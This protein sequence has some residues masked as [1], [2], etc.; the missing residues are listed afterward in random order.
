M[1]STKSKRSK[2]ADCSWRARKP[3]GRSRDD[4]RPPRFWSGGSHVIVG[5][6]AES[7]RFQGKEIRAAMAPLRPR[8]WGIGRYSP[9]RRT[10]PCASWTRVRRAWQHDRF[11]Q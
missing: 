9:N 5:S 6:A 8:Q 2:S 7:I 11:H 1:A 3:E 10:I 4:A